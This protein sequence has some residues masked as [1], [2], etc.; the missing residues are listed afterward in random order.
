MVVLGAPVLLG[1]NAGRATVIALGGSGLVLRESELPH[2]TYRAGLGF[3]FR[4]RPRFAMQFELD[5]LYDVPRGAGAE[6]PAAALV[7]G[8]GLAFGRWS[9]YEDLPD[10]ASGP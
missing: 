7:F 3:N 8:I 6:P 9:E 4:A 2:A 10:D 1:L 5:A